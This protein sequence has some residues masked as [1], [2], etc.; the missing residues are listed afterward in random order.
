MIGTARSASRGFALLAALLLLLL[1]SAIVVGVVYMVGTE[2]RLGGTDRENTLAYYGAEAGMEKMMADLSDLYTV[3]Q[4]PTV[5][6]IQAL[7]V[8]GLQPVLPGVTYPEYTFTVPNVGGVPTAEV[9]N[10]SSGPNEGLVASIIPMT[11]TVTAQRV[12]GEEVKMTRSIEV[13]LIP[14]FQFGIFSETDLSY[15]PGPGFDFAGRVH[16]NGNLFLATSAATGLVFHSK[17][18]AVREVIRQNLA[19]ITVDTVASGRDD[20]VLVPTAPNGCDGAQPAC[21][22]L[23]ENEGSKVGGVTSAD[24][25]NWPTISTTTY[26][27]MI[28]DGSTGAKPLNLPFVAPGLRPIE[29]I[30]R[31]LPGE[32]PTSL[33]AQ[34]RL[35]NQAQIRVLLSDSPADLPGGAGD[36]ENVELANTGAYAAGV[37]VPGANPTY[38]AEGIDSVA[39]DRDWVRPAGVA[40]GG[41]WPLLGGYLRVELRRADGTYLGVTREWL[42][43]G[44]ARGLGIPKT[45]PAPLVTN[46][47]HPNAILILQIL[48]D[49]N[50]DNDLGDAGEN[51]G[52][53]TGAANRNNWYP[54]N[55][56]DTR[57]GEWR[58]VPFNSDGTDA[59]CALGGI[60][61]A[62]MLD[63]NNLRRWLTGAIGVNGPQTE[64]ISQ[65]GY[66]LYFSDRRGMLPSP[67]A[68][69][70]L[71][72]EYGFE[73]II[74]P[75][76]ANGY[77][78]AGPLN[79]INP[80]GILDAPADMN[81][82]GTIDR[83][84]DVNENGVLD[85]FGR[86]NLGDGFIAAA[87]GADTAFDNPS[88]RIA[89]KILTGP[90]VGSNLAAVD[91]LARKNRVS[92]ARHGLML[93]NG[94]LGNLP[95]RPDGTGGF[96]VAS[97]NP[98]YVH[99]N[100]NAN[101]A[102]GFTDA[103]NLHAAAA[104]IADAVSFLSYQ[105]DPRNTFRNPTRVGQGTRN[106]ITS[107]YRV[108]VAEGK[109]R[110]WPHPDAWTGGPL[111]A[112]DYGLDGGTHNFLRYLERWSGQTFNYRGSLVS[113]YYSEYGNGIYKC[114]NTVYSP[115][116]RAYAFDTEFLDPAKLPPGTPKFR[117]LVNLGFQQ[118]F[119][120]N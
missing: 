113:F 26:N 68:G 81:G 64:S 8:P 115:P 10:I 69:G 33:V 62:P 89:C 106:A 47:V 37:P 15:F 70:I 36:P 24:N 53:I 30:R 32:A 79:P 111:N 114:C 63:V 107:F 82:D 45:E 101:T 14:V 17:I 80:N 94:S 99:G 35:Y 102:S 77:G 25:L 27:G 61:N 41:S 91:D 100:Y 112:Q 109:N 65:N 19:N 52:G 4:A 98:V 86:A 84:E 29:L 83:V 22:D 2:S 28:L 39:I 51:A 78:G 20:P 92:G 6:A 93:V 46:T 58:D 67:A 18:T 120:P 95:R 108:A 23:Q 104:I 7:G 110:N 105:W 13:A 59:T 12:G 21:R 34:S 48:A 60:I 66:I 38:F 96:T 97:E 43:L 103:G 50:G 5:A 90:P 75:N 57:E 31:P 116:T 119:T 42:E 118:V 49:R 76:N 40:V 74:D 9:R 54:L 87:Q 16:T 1:L 73:D 44:F 3:Q 71:T 88:R 72:G 55:L 85:T 117:D 11:L 56:Y